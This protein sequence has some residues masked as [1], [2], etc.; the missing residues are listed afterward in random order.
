LALAAPSISTSCQLNIIAGNGTAISCCDG[1]AATSGGFNG[2]H[3]IGMDSSGNFFVADASGARIRKISGGIITTVVG[4]GTAGFNGNGLPG[5]S[6]ELYFP[7]SVSFDNSGNVFF[8]EWGNFVRVWNVSTNKV[9]AVAG[10]GSAGYAGDGGPATSALLNGPVATAFDSLGNLYI[11]DFN[12]HAIRKVAAGTGIIST[13]VGTGVLGF[14][15]D[16]LSGPA[17][18]LYNPDGLNF[19]SANNLYF[20]DQHNYRIRVLYAASGKVSTVAGTGISGYSGDGGLATA[21]QIGECHDVVVDPLG[22][23]Y[24]ADTS[25]SRVRL[26]DLG[27]GIISTVVNSAGSVGFNGDHL[28]CGTSWLDDPHRLFLD[29]A[30][31]LYICDTD[32]EYLREAVNCLSATTATFTPTFSKTATPSPTPTLTQSPVPGPSFTISPTFSVSPTPSPSP[33]PPKTASRF[34]II[35]VFPNPVGPQGG[36]IVVSLPYACDLDFRLYDVRGELI[37]TAVQSYSSPGNY[38]YF[39]NASNSNG[40]PVSYGAYYLLAHADLGDRHDEDGRWLSVLR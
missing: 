38:E 32:N 29:P 26:L 37:W 1:G 17:T 33:T 4:T 23:L 13:V 40:A 39:W 28:S 19:D 10:T 3:G 6:T 8:A 25:N 14:N 27:T 21:A 18:Q 7:L 16:G 30:K 2:P 31:N 35:S 11:S 15:G 36:S 9:S 22:Y 5:T 24:I 12:N 20:C 34:K